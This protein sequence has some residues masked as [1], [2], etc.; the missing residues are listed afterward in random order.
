MDH[1]LV[2]DYVYSIWHD[3]IT[4][5]FIQNGIPAMEDNAREN[6]LHTVQSF[7]DSMKVELLEM[8]SS[9][10]LASPTF[11]I[12]ADGSIIGETNTW[13]NIRTHLAGRSY[14]SSRLG[15]GQV[16]ITPNNCGLCHGVDHPRGMCP[17]PSIDGWKGPRRYT[18]PNGQKKGANTRNSTRSPANRRF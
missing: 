15:K 6:A 9:G 11:N 8:K 14:H 18:Q 12:Y 1:K 2:R 7:M 10:G 4:S 13:S 16:V 3:N 5:Q 17:F